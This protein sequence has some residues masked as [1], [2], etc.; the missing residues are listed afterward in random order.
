MAV[1]QL[2]V[3]IPTLT[4]EPGPDDIKRLSRRLAG[5]GVTQSPLHREQRVRGAGEAE[6][7]PQFL[8]VHVLAQPP[9]STQRKVRVSRLAQCPVCLE[10]RGDDAGRA[11][12]EGGIQ[13]C[14]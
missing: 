7:Q 4:V 1:E 14:V 13:R 12:V 2:G 11:H 3:D 10:E 6:V 9:S 5:F 8:V